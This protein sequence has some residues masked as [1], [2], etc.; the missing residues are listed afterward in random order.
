MRRRKLN[1]ISILDDKY[2]ESGFVFA[3]YLNIK[4]SAGRLSASEDKNILKDKTF[5]VLHLFC[6][7]NLTW[8]YS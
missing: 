8:M 2:T 3:Q 5:K 6:F 7:G 1:L 4:S